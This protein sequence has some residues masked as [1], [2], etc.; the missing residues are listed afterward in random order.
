MKKEKGP[1]VEEFADYSTV[2]SCIG[3]G[4]DGSTLQSR[5]EGGV[6]R[7]CDPHMD[8]ETLDETTPTIHLRRRKYA[9]HI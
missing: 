7:R 3:K 5:S 9:K 8:L 2:P 4:Q 1:L 6:A